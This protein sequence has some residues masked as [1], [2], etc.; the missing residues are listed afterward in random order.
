MRPLDA[1]NL[2][3]DPRGRVS[4]VARDDPLIIYVDG[5]ACP[6]KDEVYRVAGRHQLLTRIVT[7]SWLRLPQSPLIELCV[8]AESLDAADDWI[9]AHIAANDIAITADIPLAARCLEKGAVVLGPNGKSFDDG[10]IGAALATREIMSDLRDRG[11][12]RGNNPSFTKQDR[13]RFLDTLER[14]VQIAK[15][16]PG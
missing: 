12:I 4:K 1:A 15:R 10:N 13:V 7:N 3:R 2:E 8:V 11:E 16:N 6:V 14:V 9:V 5:D